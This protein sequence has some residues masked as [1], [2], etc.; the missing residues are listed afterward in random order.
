[1]IVMMA[2]D[3]ANGY[4][5]PLSPLAATDVDPSVQLTRRRGRGALIATRAGVVV[6]V[7]EGRGHRVTVR[8]DANASDVAD[9]ARALA[10][11]LTERS[12][13]RRDVIIETID[14]ASAAQTVH[15]AAFEAAG[16]RSTGS[17]LRF[18]A[19]PR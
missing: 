3:P 1:V 16:F 12:D 5:L 2:S 9:A 15:A 14:G 8:A 17:G 10:R 19:P 6:L 11:H 13:R 4:A 7:A 18:Y